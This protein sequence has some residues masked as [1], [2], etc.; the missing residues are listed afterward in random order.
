ML[1]GETE[2]GKMNWIELEVV[3]FLFCRF[4]GKELMEKYRGKKVMFVGD[5]LSKN[6]WESMGCMLLHAA[7]NNTPTN[8]YTLSSRGPLTTL[9]FPVS[10]YYN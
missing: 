3:Q 4:Q 5:S 1:E 9:F 10:I 7:S 6:Q 8:N 2:F